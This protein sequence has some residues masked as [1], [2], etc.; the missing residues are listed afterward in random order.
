MI[1]RM[2]ISAKTLAPGA[3]S[4]QGAK[5]SRRR[6]G[7]QRKVEVLRPR[8]FWGWPE[9][10]TF[11]PGG[12]GSPQASAGARGRGTAAGHPRRAVRSAGH[13]A[14][15]PGV[16]WGGWALER[17]DAWAEY[18]EGLQYAPTADL[19]K[20]ATEQSEGRVGVRE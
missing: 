5:A 1:A 13:A 7:T 20:Q 4:G 16:V 2:Q 19:Q 11:V 15:L 12:V 9:G 10:R 8:Q 6:P 18:E 17:W 3:R 14:L